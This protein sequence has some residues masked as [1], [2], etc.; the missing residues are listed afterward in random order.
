MILP[1][2]TPVFEQKKVKP[3]DNKFSFSL[4]RDYLSKKEQGVF[5][6]HLFHLQLDKSI[7]EVFNSLFQV[8]V[9]DSVPFVL[10][11]FEKGKICGAAIYI[12]CTRYGK[13]LFNNKLLAG[14]VN[15]VNVPFYLWIKFGCCMDVMSN[16]GFVSDFNR[17]DEIYY[18]MSAYM[19]KTRLLTIVTDF[20]VN[21]SVHPGASVLPAL[22]HAL[23]DLSYFH[24][25]EDYIN[26]YKNLK[27]KIRVFNNKGG[28]C[29]IIAG[30]LDNDLLSK[31]ETCF[32]ST[33]NQSL[34]YLP[35]QDL[36][37]LVAKQTA[38]T[39]LDKVYYFIATLNGELIGY[40]TAIQTG[41]HLNALH[42]AFDRNRKTT[43]HAYDMLFV[44]MVEFA[45]A[46]N[47]EKI[48]FGAT[49]NFTKAKMINSPRPISYFIMS[50]YSLV[51]SFF[52]L[53]LNWTKIQ[54]TKL[55]QFMK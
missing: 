40:Q 18:A 10:R 53:F 33:T 55:T 45:I 38:E 42:G 54:G 50:R 37:K 12:R 20:H 49:L 28:D 51:Q 46:N 52:K 27:R 14:A 17:A 4:S 8:R 26:Q 25:T 30:R 3:D 19:S 31:M 29:S 1:N 6:N 36:Y 22:P 21:A 2:D 44:K 43:S 7:W 39:H 5:K 41:S 32:E 16:P 35:Y 24:S 48:D 13:S 34:F 11:V 15:L 9:T 23:L 47:L